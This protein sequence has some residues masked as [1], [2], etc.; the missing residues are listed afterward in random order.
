MT[1]RLAVATAVVLAAAACAGPEPEAPAPSASAP[2]PPLRPIPGGEE[3]TASPPPPPP[4]PASPAPGPRAAP[5]PAPPPAPRADPATIDVALTRA[6]RR[7]AVRVE[8]RGPWEARDGATGAVLGRGAVLDL[9]VRAAADGIRVGDAAP[10]R[11]VLLAPADAQGGVRVDGTSYAGALLLETASDGTLSLTNRVPFPAYLEGVLAGE[12]PASF[13]QEALRAQAVLARSFALA[14]LRA[15]T[16]DPGVSQAYPGAPPAAVLARLREAVRS[17]EGF[18]L[19]DTRG[20]DLPGYWYHST[21][22]GHTA[23]ATPVFGVPDSEPYRGVPCDGCGGSK[24]FRWEVELPEADVRAAL[25]FG[26]AV[27]SLEIVDRLPDGR[28]RALRARTAAGTEREI[29][30][31]AL[32]GALGPNRLRSTLLDGVA[33]VG[34]AGGRPVAWRFRGQGW[35]HGVG[36]CQIA[37]GALAERGWTADRILARYYPGSRLVRGD[38]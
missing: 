15:L 24:Y 16:D 29:T 11:R 35:G 4:R 5:P 30:A 25:R 1:R 31:V 6:G 8:V 3:G 13:P 36:L 18:R 32:R 26:S 34:P 12:M 23:A 14:N 22:G 20:A 9:E 38:G 21:C 17:T 19:V 7:P 33:P 28:A 27:A 2:L 37:A 10:S